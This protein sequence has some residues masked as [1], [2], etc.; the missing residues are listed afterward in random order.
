[1]KSLAIAATLVRSLFSI[2][3]ISCSYSNINIAC[4]CQ[5]LL[6]P[7]KAKYDNSKHLKPLKGSAATFKPL[8]GGISLSRKVT[9]IPASLQKGAIFNKANLPKTKIVNGWY[10]IPSWLAGVWHRETVTDLNEDGSQNTHTERADHL[11]G[12]QSDRFGTIWHH[13]CEPY[14]QI[15][16]QDDITYSKTIVSLQPIVMSGSEVRM[17]YKDLT[18]GYNKDNKLIV[19]THKHEQI[20]KLTRQGDLLAEE[21]WSKEYDQNGNCYSSDHAKTVYTLIHT[22][23]P[24]KVDKNGLDLE[25]H[26]A[27]FLLSHGYLDRVPLVTTEQPDRRLSVTPAK[28]K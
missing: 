13:H 10:W 17:H 24:T 28:L 20:S 14:T 23:K 2:A 1:M 11:W 12:H 9:A 26:F 27:L 21:I 3:L 7:A 18:V 6:K 25:K 8:A 19:T 16:E 22:F 5:N 15:V 4:Q